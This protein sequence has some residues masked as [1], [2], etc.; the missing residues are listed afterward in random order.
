[1]DESVEAARLEAEIA[2]MKR[3]HDQVAARLNEDL[4]VKKKTATSGLQDRLNKRKAKKE[5]EKTPQEKL[6]EYLETLRESH[7]QGGPAIKLFI[8]HE[9]RVA[10]NEFENGYM[11]PLS[12]LDNDEEDDVEIEHDDGGTA[13]MAQLTL[14]YTGLKEG[15]LA[16]YKSR[17]VYEVKAVKERGNGTVL[18]EA[19]RTAAWSLAAAQ[20]IKRSS[21][22][23]RT[24]LEKRGVELQKAYEKL[25]KDGASATKKEEA[26]RRLATRDVDA[27]GREQQ[28]VYATLAGIWVDMDRCL[29]RAHDPVSSE[30]RGIQVYRYS[31]FAIQIYFL[32]GYCYRDFKT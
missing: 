1:V 5:T 29:S 25:V 22:D 26:L 24:L 8:D 21:R 14:K 9:K 2:E 20:L 13:A 4:T 10:V 28:K 3:V 31:S 27:V 12:V 11:R 15:M 32:V 23:M 6:E 18:T 7:K 16:G 17:C 19:E 30:L